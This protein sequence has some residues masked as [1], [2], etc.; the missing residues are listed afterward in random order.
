MKVKSWDR[1]YFSPLDRQKGSVV[2]GCGV[3]SEIDGAF[4]KRN[5]L[6]YWPTYLSCLSKRFQTDYS[7]EGNFLN[8]NQVL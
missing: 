8:E 3:F 4:L 7:S 1:T 6:D 5:G 2:L